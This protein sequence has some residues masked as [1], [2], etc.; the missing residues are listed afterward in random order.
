[1]ISK[2]KFYELENNVELMN[3]LLENQDGI[4]EVIS[5][6]YKKPYAI[7]ICHADATSKPR[8]S[9]I[10]RKKLYTLNSQQE[11]RNSEIIAKLGNLS[12]ILRLNNKSKIV[13]ESL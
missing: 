6:T 1:M 5:Y 2:R 9:R 12:Q 13:T 3:I 8:S 7:Q 11:H 4:Y 10:D